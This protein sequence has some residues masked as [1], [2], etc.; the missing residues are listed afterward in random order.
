MCR[1][2]L[3]VC[4]M[5]RNNE[6]PFFITTCPEMPFE[7]VSARAGLEMCLKINVY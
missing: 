3:S 1:E 6:N 7:G 5:A 4:T 2:N